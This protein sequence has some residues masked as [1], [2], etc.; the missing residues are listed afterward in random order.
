[1]QCFLETIILLWSREIF[2]TVQSQYVG[3][4][5]IRNYENREKAL[6]KLRK[7]TEMPSLT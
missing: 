7:F 6:T 5:K 1:M 4:T 3:Y 2:V